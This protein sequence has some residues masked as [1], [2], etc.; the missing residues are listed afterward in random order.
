VLLDLAGATGTSTDEL[1]AGMYKIESAGSTA[2]T[3]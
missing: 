1:T 3:R 2:P